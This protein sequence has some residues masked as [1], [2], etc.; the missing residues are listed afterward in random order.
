MAED[1]RL[2]VGTKIVDS[3]IQEQLD[4]MKKKTITVTPTVKGVKEVKVL[5]DELGKIYKVTSKFN[6]EGVKLNTTL[7]SMQEGFK[8]VAKDTK[9]AT[10]EMKKFTDAEGKVVVQTSKFNS[11]GESLGVTTKS[12]SNDIAKAEKHVSS[13]G[14][15]FVANTKKVAQFAMST[16]LIGGFTSAIYKATEAIKEY[17]DAQIEASKV[18]NMS[19]D[20][21]QAYGES[22]GEVGTTISRTR[23]EMLNTATEFLKAGYTEEQSKQLAKVAG[24]Y[25]NVADSELTA[26]QSAS[27]VI[28][29]M[30]AFNITAEDS[31]Q[32]IDKINELS[33]LYAVSST[34]IS[35]GLTKTAST[36]ATYGNS[37][38][39]TMAMIV[40]A[41][42][43]MP[44]Q[45][46]K[47]S[48]GLS[49][50]GAELVKLANTT[51]EVTYEVDGVTKSLSL[52][53]EQGN[54]LSTF[55]T[56]KSIKKDWDDMTTAEQS[57][58]ALMLGM[59]TQIPVFTAEMNN[60]DTVIKAVTTSQQSMGSATKENEKYMQGLKAK[61]T[62]LKAE[63]ENLVLG[64]G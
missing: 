10:T 20:E 29:Q 53:D 64:E 23:T 58:L 38:D 42:E 55:D 28:S 34:D 33:N 50:I 36:F 14:E 46:G 37:I 16:A 57:N 43:L 1:F 48:R 49:S 61:L 62:L 21:M 39:E 17:D 54:M 31:V 22:L 11:A 59:K 19:A 51:K 47:V 8:D 41:T 27:F 45:A 52:F 25:Q 56:L 12:M 6:K 40:G 30:K 15:K 2:L 35:T 5:E 24:M 13:L 44:K 3:K 9:V 60:F 32:I 63:F 7:S 18:S 4:A 26:G